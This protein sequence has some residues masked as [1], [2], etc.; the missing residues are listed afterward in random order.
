MSSAW[1]PEKIKK[2]RN[3]ARFFTEQ[4][5]VAWVML[6]ATLLW[7]LYGYVMMPKRKDP[8]IPVRFAAV[9]GSWPGASAEDVEELLTQRI[10]DAIAENGRIE[11]I[12]ST[13]R[14]GVTIVS[15]RLRQGLTST[16][17]DEQLDDLWLRL[18]SLGN[19]PPG[20][21]VD[22]LKDFGDT[23]ALM[24]TIASPRASDIEIQLRARRIAREIERTRQGAVTSEGAHR[25]TL[26][27]C[28]PH[29]LPVDEMRQ[30]GHQLA[31]YAESR[32]A[33]DLR[34]IDGPGF[35]AIDSSTTA[36]D[37]RIIENA[38][39]FVQ[40]RLRV[41]ELHPDVWDLF[42]VQN[43]AD[44]E[45]RLTGAAG[46]RYTYR[47]LDEFADDLE[48]RLRNLDL[49][50]K[51]TR[52]G[53]LGEEIVLEYSQE[54]LAAYGLTPQRLREAIGAR[55]TLAPGGV[56]EAHGKLVLVDPS[57]EL[58]T[59]REIG[60]IAITTSTTGTPVYLRD[61]VDIHRGYQSPPRYLNTY[62]RVN[63]DAPLARTRAITLGVYMRSGGQIQE[64]G[65]AIDTTL[66]SARQLLPEDLIIARTSDQP[67]QV[68]ENVGLF[69][70]SLYEAIILVV[71]VALIGFWEW[72][73]ALLMALTIPIT[74]AMTFGMMHLLG[75]DVQQVSVAS[76]IIALGLLVDDPVVAGDAIK[77]EL[78]HG[79]DRITAAWLGPTKLAT[80]IL[81]ATITNIVAYLPFL[82]MNDD[83][84]KF[85]YSLP[86][87]LTC[88]LVASRLVS[89]TFVP[90]L[91][92][93]LLRA[94]KKLDASMAERKKKGFAKAYSRLVGFAID[95]RRWVLAG[96]VLLLA[97]GVFGIRG[98]KQ[99]FFPKDLS[100]LS[101]VDVWLPEDAPLFRTMI[102]ARDTEEVI[103][104]VANEYGKHPE[105]GEPR[106]VLASLTT[107]IGGG[108]PRFWFSLAPEQRQ[109]NYAQIVVQVNDKH[110]TAPL[111]ARLQSAFEAEIPGARVDARQLE[112]GA[113]VGI[114]VQIRVSGEDIEEL[115]AQAERVK[116]ILEQTGIAERIRDNWGA[117]SFRVRLEVDA[118]RANLAGVTNLDVAQSSA[119][120]LNG[121]MVGV[122]REEERQ[123]PIVARL[124][125]SERSQ[126]T[127]LDNLYVYSANGSVPLRQISSV[128]YGFV[129]EKIVRRNH[130][131]TITIAAFPSEGVLASEVLAKAKPALDA[132]S[133]DLPPGYE[134]SVGGEQEEQKKGFKNLAIVL[135]ISVV[136]IFLALVFQF[137]DAVKPLLVFAA[138]PFG[139]VG[140]LMSLLVMDAPF[141]FMAFLGAIS[142]IGVIV[143][144]VIVL[145]DFIEEQRE[146]GAPLRD[147]LVDAG[148][149]RLRPVLVTV[150]ATVFGLFP[151]ALNGGPLW[152]PL[153]YVQIGGLTLAT[154]ITLLLVPV[155]YA[156]CVFDLKVVKWDAVPH[157]HPSEPPKPKPPEP[158]SS[159]E[160]ASG[161]ATIPEATRPE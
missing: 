47:Q 152:E 30:V 103:A 6:I 140:G 106:D 71:L 59:E 110:D 36:A 16:S 150:G 128:A 143:S 1:T 25:A 61:L 93:V 91:G 77:R 131:R 92:Y 153:C 125:G 22:F 70:R 142:L 51:V 130:Y 97:A 56:M 55:N 52:V 86:V 145:F 23:A 46:D 19:L 85:I 57:G 118:D 50:S 26:V 13:T 114:P 98:I 159:I 45:A 38:Q 102:T 80:A 94:P 34:L 144:H 65:D 139:V 99:A 21:R 43:V 40:D 87:V 109:P 17:R 141:G 156:F 147:A 8:E 120:A 75:I 42:V 88:S 122:L 18:S 101:Y 89:M 127:E 10:E 27:V 108:G 136:A 11:R 53:S 20:A 48:Q 123:I 149:L 2:T 29:D 100:Y 58:S 82:T 124:R 160:L 105:R 133:R 111:V 84:G 157:A 69:M 64:L 107:F 79:T 151:L 116:A 67:K 148:I 113:P 138:I 7:G 5:P 60:D 137:R 90:L 76:L 35:L 24:L 12:E 66:Q 14:T 28:F 63:G 41:S 132:L 119:A 146:E 154:V 135:G 95:R 74:L 73:S 161:D 15:L 39:E 129:T 158:P 37:E 62:T 121:A 78:A 134:L 49:V 115:R 33:T 9:I 96:F 3:T 31:T 155:L 104:R 117:E 54:R 112:T 83:T 126:I 44:T 4:R 81:F 72:R 32:G 68:S